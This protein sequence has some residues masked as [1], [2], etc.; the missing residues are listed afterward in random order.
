MQR[1]TPGLAVALLAVLL[2]CVTVVGQALPTA[3]QRQRRTRTREYVIWLEVR[4]S[5]RP[6]VIC[7]GE[8]KELL[9]QVIAFG[10]DH[11]IR[12]GAGLVQPS[13]LDATNDQLRRARLQK[14]DNQPENYGMVGPY[15]GERFDITGLRPGEGLLTFKATWYDI[16][17]P[18]ST[19]VKYKV[20]KCDYEATTVQTL[21]APTAFLA[22]T[23]DDVQ[24]TADD[25]GRLSGTGVPQW[26]VRVH[27]LPCDVRPTV[28]DARP[29]EITG[30]IAEDGTLNLDVDHADVS[31]RLA[32]RCPRRMLGVSRTWTDT[33]GLSDRH[34]TVPGDGGAVSTIQS[35]PG[36]RET[37]SITVEP[38]ERQAV[39]VVASRL[40][41]AATPGSAV[42]GSRVPSAEAGRSPT[43]A[44]SPAPS[45]VAV[46]IEVA[47]G[48][49]DLLDPTVGLAD[50]AS[51]VASLTNAFAGTVSGEPFDASTTATMR[52]APS[53]RELIIERGADGPT[54]WRAEVRGFSYA[55][56]GDGP[57]IAG[58]VADGETLADL[59]EPA[60]E[61]P[62][63]FGAS[64]AVSAPVE[65][66]P[67]GRH[68]FDEASLVVPV[69]ATVTGDVWIAESD[70][71]VLRYRAQVEAGPE[72][73]GEGVIGTISFDYTLSTPERPPRISLPADCPPAVDAPVPSGATEVVR[74]PGIL[75]FNSSTAI[76][77]ASRSYT[78][79]LRDEGWRTTF[80]A[81]VTRSTALLGFRKGKRDLTVVMRRQ[82]GETRVHVAVT[83]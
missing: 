2:A 54:T 75:S 73:L 23:M 13:T 46:T 32:M 14:A 1:P 25:T 31:V 4:P 53:G 5:H 51:Y 7:V 35:L 63:L 26:V 71:S 19:T 80:P 74:R 17:E 15:Q 72:I 65:G 44:V 38:V 12:M 16:A 59:F 3:G 60:A 22:M 41:L 27:G 66:A 37:A 43:P 55:K 9:V 33:W 45:G 64:E 30:E 77:R 67:A 50:R 24:V 28:T 52:V 6:L 82:S 49:F 56:E 29:V 21:T 78:R 8:R 70:G 36:F 34:I 79:Q 20:Q 69:P 10:G 39:A 62:P 58:T 57:C 40:L 68:T 11:I 61:L 81:E 42:T 76:A 48:P 18:A 83:R 47:D